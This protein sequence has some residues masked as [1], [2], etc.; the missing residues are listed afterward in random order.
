MV[1]LDN[2]DLFPLFIMPGLVV[3]FYITL[4][5]HLAA[6][7][8][9]S[10]DLFYVDSRLALLY[11]CLGIF[12]MI[13]GALS[14][15]IYDKIGMRQTIVF[16]LINMFMGGVFTY[17][18]YLYD[19]FYLFFPAMACFGMSECGTGTFV[20]SLFSDIFGVKFE[21][22]SGYFLVSGS[23]TAVMVV[24]GAVLKDLNPIYFISVYTIV[25]IFAAIS[26]L[27]SRIFDDYK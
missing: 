1:T 9:H 19:S 10:S 22:H 20:G 16:L 2:W 17:L 12:E 13:T 11:F 18:G 6:M 27:S 15:L 25:L 4:I 26:S 7:T 21:P 24:L 3:G 8:L 23:T 14:G 5:P